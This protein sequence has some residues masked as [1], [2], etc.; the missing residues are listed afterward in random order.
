MRAALVAVKSGKQVAILVPTTLL[1]QHYDTLKDRFAQWPFIIELV[2][3][4]RPKSEIDEIALGCASGKVDIVVGTHKL[5]GEEFK[6][7]E[8][9]LVVIDEEHRFGVRQKE[10]M[11]AFRRKRCFNFDRHSNTKNS[12]Y[13]VGGIRD[14]SII[15]T[16]P[17]KRLSIKPSCTKRDRI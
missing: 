13:V 15:S 6:F 14:L 10:L 16:P 5:F 2:S 7:K 3:R 11:R 1:A 8:L 4:L 12:K 9:G 17:A